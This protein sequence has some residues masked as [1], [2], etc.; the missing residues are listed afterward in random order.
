MSS[1]NISDREYAELQSELRELRKLKDGIESRGEAKSKVRLFLMKLWAGPELSKSLEAWMVAKEANDASQT[2]TATANLIAAVFRRFMRVG[3][4]FVLLALIP[5]ILIIWQ[6]IIMERQNQSL[7]KQIEAERTASSNQQVTEYLRLLLSNDK[8]E[9][10]AAEGFL[11]SDVVN[12][13]IAVERLSALLKSGNTDV[14]CSALRALT[15]IV[16]SSPELTLQAAIAPQD[17]SRIY[18]SDLQCGKVNFTGVDFG[19]IT[20]SDIGFPQSDFAS[21]DLSDVEFQDSNLRHSDLSETFL[22]ADKTRC[23]T[24]FETDL[25]HSSLLFS[26]QSKDVFR[27]GAILKGAQMRFDRDFVD[28]ADRASGEA[29]AAQIKSSRLVVPKIPQD[30]TI[31]SGLCYEASYSQCYLYHKAKDIGNLDAQR[32]NTIRHNNCPINLDGPIVL[33][34][35]STCEALGLQPRW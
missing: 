12:R 10:T 22:C 34:A 14:E 5:I 29:G 21:A 17:K 7:I 4:I 31:A 27:S 28:Q 32:L 24:F 6:N 1:P 11:V 18:L 19:A 2:I 23:V 26:N 35:V 9:V 30:N 8:K 15:R 20:F 3:L 33:T 13:G 25:S 16:E